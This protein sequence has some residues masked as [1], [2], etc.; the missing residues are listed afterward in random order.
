[1]KADLNNHELDELDALL[2]QAPQALDPLDVIS[3]DGYLCAVAVQPR[4]VPPADWLARALDLEGT[5]W[6]PAGLDEVWLQRVRSLTQR[7]FEAL[8]RGLSED[9]VFD[10]VV[11]DTAAL[12]AQDAAGA[13][14]ADGNAVPQ[15]GPAAEPKAQGASEA[16]AEP[17]T[18][19]DAEPATEADAGSP[20]EDVPPHSRALVH[21]ASGF[22]YGCEV[23]EALLDHPDEAVHLAISR[24]LRHLPPQNDEDRQLVAELDAQHPLRDESHAIEDVVEAAVTLWELTAR[25]RLAVRTVQ[26]EGAKVGRNDPCPCGSGRKFKQCH[27]KT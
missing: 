23:F 20:E 21:W 19:A 5:R 4:I 8:V 27:G 11:S 6:P 9:R 22:L 26:R 25:D 24:I 7:R 1:M 15:A 2:G 16:G 14:P 12:A 13:E 3:L 17:A 10:P 18:A